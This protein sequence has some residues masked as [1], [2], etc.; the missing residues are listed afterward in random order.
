MSLRT[1]AATAGAI[2]WG[3][4]AIG[5]CGGHGSIDS[6]D[7]SAQA[8]VRQFLPDAM[9]IRCSRD[10]ASVVRCHAL[11]GDVLRGIETWTCE[12]TVDPA[13]ERQSYGGSRSCWSRN[14][15]PGSLRDGRLIDLD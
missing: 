6:A 4:L 10:E 13:S 1:W 11:V 3:C 8:H 14:G 2:A 9:V 12:F 15:R 5:G 7:R